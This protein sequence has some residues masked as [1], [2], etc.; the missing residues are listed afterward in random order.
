MLIF[1][2]ICFAGWQA[3]KR[4]GVPAAAILGPIAALSVANFFGLKLTVSLLLKPVLSM[5]LGT[6]L[7]LRFNLK[8]KGILKTGLLMSVWMIFTA[9]ITGAILTR[10]GLDKATA[11]F[12]ATPGGL[13]EMGLIAMSFGA[14]V[15]KVALLQSTRLLSAMFVIPLLAKKVMVPEN[16]ESSSEQAEGV[17]PTPYDW[18]A[19]GGLALLSSLLLGRIHLSANFLVGPLLFVGIYTKLRS[20]KVQ[21]SRWLQN[22]AQ[23]GVGGLIG[24]N[25]AK[26]SI[27][28]IPKLLPAIVILNI[29]IVGSSLI[30][31]YVFH[32]LTQ[33]D[34]TTCLLAA[35]PAG[36]TAITVMAAELNADVSRVAVLQLIRLITVVLVTPL[37]FSLMLGG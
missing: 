1:Y 16:C 37:Q 22:F 15:F 20:L 21:P 35:S 24:L 3:G 31:G 10:I 14:D 27:L 33:W 32:K 19:I 17:V 2:I 6:V 34:L 13:A 36:L 9:D 28:A 18:L 26:E 29:L 11:V 8:L 5:I 12:A 30:L 25:V 23:I 7:G 4:F